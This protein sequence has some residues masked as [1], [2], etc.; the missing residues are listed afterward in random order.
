MSYSSGSTRRFIRWRRGIISRERP[1]GSGRR[2]RD[3]CSASRRAMHLG[4]E[5]LTAGLHDVMLPDY[6]IGFTDVVKRATARADELDP[7]E[8]ATATCD[9]IGETHDRFQ[10]GI[11]C[12][13]RD[14]GVSPVRPP[15]CPNADRRPVGGP[16]AAFAS[17]KPGCSSF[18]TEVPPTRTLLQPRKPSGL[19][20]PRRRS[21]IK[22]FEQ[23]YD[24]IHPT[25]RP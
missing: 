19:R 15:P 25:M 20:P 1:T 22:A 12:F 13:P 4:V 8:F 2:S 24:N 21:P 23:L 18:Q 11:A 9:L 3:R 14:D 6:G 17:A 5:H 10:P 16:A 7:I